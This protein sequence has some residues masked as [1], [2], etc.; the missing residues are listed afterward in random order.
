[1]TLH[2][3][4]QG[5]KGVITKVRGRGAFRKRITEMGFVKGKIITVIRKAP[6]KD[7]IEYNIMDYQVSLRRSEAKLVEVI[8]ENEARNSKK[9]NS[10]FNGTITNEILKNTAKKKGEIIDVAL[11]GNPNSGKTTLFNFASGSKEHVGN[12]GG[13]TI[14]LK[15][16]KFKQ[17][18]YTFNIIDLPGT[19]SLTAYTPEEL[20]VRKYILGSVP[21]VVIN[22][23]DASNL[24]R[25]LYLTTQLIDMDIKVIVA[26]NMYDELSAKGDKFDY[27]SLGKM[28]GIPFVPT[29]ASK[30]KG[31]KEL[32][33]KVIDVYEDND[34][35]VR[36]IHINYGKGVETSIKNIQDKI[37]ENKSLTDKVSSRFYAIKLLEKDNGVKFSLSRLNNYNDIK[38]T[39][40]A[41]INKLESHLNEDSETLITD[42]KYGFIAGAL[43]ETFQSNKQKRKLKTDTE[44]IDTFITHRLFGFPIFI[45][46]LWLMFQSTFSIGAFPMRWIEQLISII[47]RNIENI[48]PSG[49][50]KDLIVDGIIGGVGGVIIFLPNILILFFFISL[51]EDTGYMARAA[52]IM[53]KLMHKI[54]LHGKSFIPL[55]MGFGCNVP[56]IMAT[57][58]LE[59]KN[60]R[61][62]TMLINPFMSCSA[63]LPV[64]VLLIGAFFPEYPGTVLFSI[65]SIGILIAIGVAIVFKKTIFKSKEVPF[66]MELPPYRIPTLRTIIRHM[67]HKASLYLR[68]MG[69]VI[70]IAS[71]IIWALGYFPREIENSKKINS[72]INQTELEYTQQLDL[73]SS[74]DTL[75]IK[76]LLKEKET[77]VR[78]LELRKENEH[79][80]NSYIG[81]IG[82]FI[83]PVMKPLG[84]DWKMSVSLL[85]GVAAKEIV[86]STMGVLYQADTNDDNVSNNLKTTLQTQ[87]YKNGD[88]KGKNIFTPLIAF[89]FIMF[90]LIYFPCVAVIVAIKKESGNWKWAL[91]MVV[92]TTSLAWL[93]SFSVYQVGSLF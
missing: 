35:T 27:K 26:L 82:H 72:I 74:T 75:K 11:V 29:V 31:I 65:Y 84:F 57:R 10:D 8:T 62:L 60:D 42:A 50:L 91:F 49:I 66:V 56:A 81:R 3:L 33:Q 28:I 14:D 93:I 71:I 12:Y 17:N 41:E 51:M 77:T 6:L 68:K 25:N 86:V 47:G 87:T 37:W 46:F 61:L 32:F 73:I 20:Y 43:K 79:Q 34:P 70:L 13:V 78:S 76:E 16:A 36:H 58:T 45:F 80:A 9:A 15:Q 63:R 1:M 83:E 19:Y 23:V 64:Y 38:E 85:A 48:M 4:N 88:K 67:W 39:L 52:F 92:Y 59:N 18:G 22:V 7:P 30:R 5:E 24:E 55:V 40:A 53:D 69:G 54:G 44:I 89:A 21:D 90:I 2:E